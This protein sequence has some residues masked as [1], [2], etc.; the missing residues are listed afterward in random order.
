M[1]SILDND[2][3]APDADAVSIKDRAARELTALE[4]QARE[5]PDAGDA[6]T[7]PAGDAIQDAADRG[8]TLMLAQL[9][10]GLFSAIAPAWKVTEDEAALLAQVW[11]PV[12]DKWLPG[13]EENP[14]GLAVFAT[15]GVLGT[16]IGKPRKAAPIEGQAREVP[17]AGEGPKNPPGWGTGTAGVNPR[18]PANG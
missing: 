6:P 17:A 14:E 2:Y 5:V 1:G 4:G 11:V 3:P 16:R 13:W 9:V 10:H 18:G 12:L 15:A 7:P 8:C